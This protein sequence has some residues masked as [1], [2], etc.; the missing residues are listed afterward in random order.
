VR[1]NQLPLNT[2]LPFTFQTHAALAA[3]LLND[4]RGRAWF[5][6]YHLQLFAGTFAWNPDDYE[7]TYL[8]GNVYENYV[9][10]PLLELE[11]FHVSD[12]QKQWPS[13]Y[14]FL[15][16]H[17][18]NGR[19]VCPLIN[20]RYLLLGASSVTERA[21][22][23]KDNIE[24]EVFYGYDDVQQIFHLF[25]HSDQL[26]KITKFSERYEDVEK[27]FTYTHI[28]G[29]YH[30]DLGEK[31]GASSYIV[32]NKAT[33]YIFSPEMAV[34]F[35]ECQRDSVN[36]WPEVKQPQYASQVFGVK[37]YDLLRKRLERIRAG[38]SIPLSSYHIKTIQDHKS[39]MIAFVH[40]LISHIFPQHAEALSEVMN[41]YTVL[42]K[43]CG[44]M[45][46]L[47]I[48]F[49]MTKN[50]IIVDR[51]EQCLSDITEKER[52]AINQLLFILD[53]G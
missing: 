5:Y 36:A 49:N 31:Y 3:I 22:R 45:M 47:S 50:P 53:R 1:Q 7:V 23:R 39:L 9:H 21:L 13:A 16:Y 17:L 2:S 33:E 30:Y 14:A 25:G 27:A 43:L 28:P 52:E 51:M 20:D 4:E 11:L 29:T 32:T 37:A 40:Y 18:N 6:T 41:A 34:H 46:Q 26:L 12:I 24:M 48:K 10:C 8:I 35:L 42:E 19:Y 38:E 44:S 15:Q